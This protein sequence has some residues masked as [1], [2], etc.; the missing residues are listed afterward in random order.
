M[1]SAGGSREALRRV[2]GGGR[3]AVTSHLFL[4]MAQLNRE[5]T[6]S[7]RVSSCESRP[8]R[9]PVTA[10]AVASS[11]PQPPLWPDCD[12]RNQI[13]VVATEPRLRGDLSH[14]EAS[15][16]QHVIDANEGRNNGTV[17]PRHVSRLPARRRPVSEAVVE[18]GNETSVSPGGVE[19]PDHE[20]PAV[21]TRSH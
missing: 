10:L 2:D 21:S 6:E 1:P 8:L 15:S 14:G 5:G 19:V 17:R 7:V 13:T 16:C 4:L 9:K 18:K 12:R 3:P 20:H 11:A